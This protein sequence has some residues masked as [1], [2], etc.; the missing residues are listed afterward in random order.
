MISGS[1]SCIKSLDNSINKDLL[2]IGRLSN[3][4]L[5]ILKAPYIDAI[6]KG[7]KQI[8]SRFANSRPGFLSTVTAGDKIFLKVSS[9]PVLAT[10]I[11]S[12]AKYFDLLTPEKVRQLKD[13]YDHLICGHD[14]YWQAKENAKFALLIWL[15]SVKKTDPVY[16]N[17][18]DR[19]AWVLLTPTKNFGLL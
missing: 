15:K 19:R 5:A 7:K 3:C 18:R 9:G 13:K 12:K 8:E 11:V 14:D 10:A 16:I 4:H 2:G 17:K 6:V 1:F